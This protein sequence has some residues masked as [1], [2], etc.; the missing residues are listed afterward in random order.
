MDC[1]FEITFPLVLECSSTFSIS[2]DLKA[3]PKLEL[4]KGIYFF[5]GDNGSGKTSFL[6]M[7]SLVAGSIGPKSTANSGNI[8]FNNKD[9]NKDKFTHIRAAEMR[10]KYFCIFPQKV[11]FLPVSS[12]DNYKML[13]GSDQLKAKVFSKSEY[14]DYLSGGQQQKLL[15]DIVLDEKKPVW[16]LDEPLANLDK[17]MRCYFW[18]TLDNAY[19][20]ELK[21]I[22]YIDHWL[23]EE[24]ESNIDFHYYNSL[25]VSVTY[26][27]KTNTKLRNIDIFENTLPE[28]FINKQI[29][30]IDKNLL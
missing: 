1:C 19:K 13:N 22:C 11:F 14:P 5:K 16:F 29:K 23:G 25:Q 15:M 24:I 26:N 17:K 4:N 12:Y 27:K 30:I 10:E 8:Q 28:R 9:Y 3:G 2:F 20:K 7:I 18:K 6:N 21:T